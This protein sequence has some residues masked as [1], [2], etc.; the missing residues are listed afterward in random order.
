MR[1]FLCEDYDVEWLLGELLIPGNI[2]RVD[3]ESIVNQLTSSPKSANFCAIT[4]PLKVFLDFIT[5]Y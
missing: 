5:L 4:I 1:K 3:L 2:K